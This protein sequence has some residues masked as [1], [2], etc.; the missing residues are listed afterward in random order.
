MFEELVKGGLTRYVAV[1]QSDIPEEIGP[2]RS[3]RPM[4]GGRHRS[5]LLRITGWCTGSGI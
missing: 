1:W 3:I 2:V 4:D 5:R